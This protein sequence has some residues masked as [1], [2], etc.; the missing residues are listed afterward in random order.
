[1][2]MIV[3]FVHSLL[4]VTT[5]KANACSPWTSCICD[6]CARISIEIVWENLSQKRRGT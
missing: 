5:E 6:V 4:T 1:M 2:K 3:D